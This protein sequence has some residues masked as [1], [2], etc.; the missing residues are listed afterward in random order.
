MAVE[1]NPVD[2][3]LHRRVSNYSNPNTAIVLS[4]KLG[5]GHPQV[6]DTLEVVRAAEAVTGIA[7]KIYKRQP[8][9]SLTRLNEHVSNV[10]SHISKMDVGVSDSNVVETFNKVNQYVSE[11]LPNIFNEGGHPAFFNQKNSAHISEVFMLNSFFS[12]NPDYLPCVIDVASRAVLKD[13]AEQM[14]HVKQTSSAR[15][16]LNSRN[17]PGESKDAKEVEQRALTNNLVGTVVKKIHS[18]NPNMFPDD[19]RLHANKA[20]LRVRKSGSL[21][22]VGDYLKENGLLRNDSGQKT[23]LVYKSGENKEQVRALVDF[24]SKN[25]HLQPLFVNKAVT[26]ITAEERRRG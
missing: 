14:S 21:G 6:G 23:G 11:K 19:L 22:A 18:V 16:Y 9:V 4:A 1:S 15:D 5:K 3:A 10:L 26:R 17:A 8:D 25:S 20:L 24:F 12:R 7:W 2:Y 13:Q